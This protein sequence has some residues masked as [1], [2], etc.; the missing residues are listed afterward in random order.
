[1]AIGYLAVLLGNLCLHEEVKPQIRSRLPGQTIRPIQHAAVEF[2]QYH[3]EV[4]AQL[5]ES[6]HRG[7]SSDGFTEKLQKMIE[8]LLEV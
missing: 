5:S 2:L 8:R 3:K 6:D 7:R 4:D 1:M